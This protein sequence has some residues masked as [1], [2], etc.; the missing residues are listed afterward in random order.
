MSLAL[1]KAKDED[2]VANSAQ[3]RHQSP[4]HFSSWA[5]C[6][7]EMGGSEVGRGPS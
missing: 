1:R 2:E 6:G 4:L 7:G 5:R 3:I